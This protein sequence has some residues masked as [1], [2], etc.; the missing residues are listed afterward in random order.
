MLDGKVQTFKIPPAC[1]L[2]QKMH[3]TGN[4]LSQ[5]IIM[6][7]SEFSSITSFIW[8]VYLI[9]NIFMLQYHI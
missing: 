1:I 6:I 5:K 7:H 4:F 2:Y 3:T 9:A 8:L